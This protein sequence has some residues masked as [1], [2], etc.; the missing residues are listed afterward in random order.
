MEAFGRAGR[1]P[2]ART[3]NIGTAYGLLLRSHRLEF[4]REF[5]D[6]VRDDPFP[7]V[8]PVELPRRLMSKRHYISMY[9]HSVLAAAKSTGSERKA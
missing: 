7:V 6:E 4:A 8:S 1:P 5:N 2:V 9:L 3:D